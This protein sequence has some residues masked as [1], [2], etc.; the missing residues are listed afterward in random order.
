MDT[1]LYTNLVNDIK[2]KIISGELSPGDRLPSE[3]ELLDIYN[4]SKTTIS[5]SMQVLANEGYIVTVPR[6][7]NFVSKPTVS[8]YQFRYNENEI[9]KRISNKSSVCNFKILKGNEKYTKAIEY[10]N[11][12]FKDSMPVSYIASTIYYHSENDLSKDDIV[13]MEYF[14][15][16]K[17]YHNL[18]ALKKKISIEAVICPQKICELLKLR[19]N[20]SVLKVTAQYYDNENTLV[21]SRVAYYNSNYIDILA[22]ER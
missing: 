9:L 20:D 19:I 18:H 16:V 8:K 7:G 6:I 2:N 13:L 17:R 15:I 21:G 1:K 11:I 12:Y 3:N 5:K 4:I 22:V 14:D 10:T